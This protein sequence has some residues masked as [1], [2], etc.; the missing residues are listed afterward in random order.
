MYAVILQTWNSGWIIQ[1][2]VW[3]LSIMIYT[4]SAEWSPRQTAVWA[5]SGRQPPS[6]GPGKEPVSVQSQICSIWGQCIIMSIL[7]FIL[8]I[9]L[10]ITFSHYHFHLLHSAE[11]YCP[12]HLTSSTTCQ[13]ELGCSWRRAWYVHFNPFINV[14]IHSCKLYSKIERVLISG[15]SLYECLWQIK[16]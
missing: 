12:S 8:F 1:L 2:I 10:F 13:M 4:F 5:A 3:C 6:V 15:R 7:C 11:I 9:Y 16:I 14:H